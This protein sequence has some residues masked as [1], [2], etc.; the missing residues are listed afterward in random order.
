MKTFRVY[1]NAFEYITVESDDFKLE[2]GGILEFYNRKFRNPDAP[3]CIL[4][5]YDDIL[6][7]SFNWKNIFGFMEVDT[8]DGEG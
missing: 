5:V 1:L 2:D 8:N 7:A 4:Q 3:G 6:V